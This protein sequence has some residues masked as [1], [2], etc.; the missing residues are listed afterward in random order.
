[1]SKPFIYIASPYTKGDQAI[2][3]RS[4]LALFDE[5]MNDGLVIPYAPLISH[6][7][8]FLFPRPYQDWVD[9]DL[10]L[11]PRFDACLRVNA[12]YADLDYDV[13]E[14]KGADG[15]VMRFR[16]LGKP[17]F[18]DKEILYS[19]VRTGKYE[20]CE[21]SSNPFWMNHVLSH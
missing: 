3:T 8:H 6:F 4:Q 5:L 18:Y 20:P 11:I 19:W 1:M 21:D 15:E 14:S 10:A 12:T 2:N 9:Y 16:E 7:Q 17:V 13:M